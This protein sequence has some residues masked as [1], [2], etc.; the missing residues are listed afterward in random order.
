MVSCPRPLSPEFS[1]GMCNRTIY[2]EQKIPNSI[3][4]SHLVYSTMESKWRKIP[5]S[6]Y[7]MNIIIEILKPSKPTVLKLS[8]PNSKMDS[9]HLTTTAAWLKSSRRWLRRRICVFL[10]HSLRVSGSNMANDWRR[11]REQYDNYEMAADLTDKTQ[12][13]SELPCS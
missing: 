11:F 13:L 1:L 6:F 8:S 2:F 9:K 10:T 12:E 4:I 3:I 7:T 5:F